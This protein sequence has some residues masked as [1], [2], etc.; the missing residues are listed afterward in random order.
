MYMKVMEIANF[1]TNKHK[2]LDESE[3]ID[4]I[5]EPYGSEEKILSI[6][7]VSRR[8][9]LIKFERFETI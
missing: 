8:P 7:L 2:F 3:L 6:E 9:I 1:F 4:F 5:T